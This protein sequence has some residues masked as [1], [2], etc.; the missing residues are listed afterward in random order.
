MRYA[1]PTWQPVGGRRGGDGSR[2]GGGAVSAVEVLAM[3]CA[4]G[5]LAVWLFYPLVIAAL[6]S[7]RRTGGGA[8]PE[9]RATVRP[10]T[11][12]IIIATCDDARTVRARVR[13]C[14]R[15]APDPGALEVVVGLDAGNARTTAHELTIP[16]DEAEPHSG[17]GSGTVRVVQGDAP[18][19]KAATL[20]A[21][22]RAARGD[23]LVFT[24][25]GQCFEPDAI[26]RLAEAFED[27]RVGAASGRLELGGGARRSL[28][29]RYWSYERWLR[30]CEATLHSC[31]GATGAIW[32]VRRSLWQPLPPRLIL[33]DVYAPMRVVLSGYRVAFV[34]AARALD[35]RVSDRTREYHRKVRTLTGV[36]QLCCWLPQLLLPSRN[37]LWVQFV[38]HK[39]LRLLTPYWLLGLLACGTLL[40]V[41]W[42]QSRPA[43][44]A[45]PVLALAA[46]SAAGKARALRVAREMLLWGFTLQLAVVA[47]GVNAARGRWDVWRTG[48]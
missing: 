28:A 3:F 37:P 40:G 24:D 30:R 26:A 15:A 8:S 31:V 13:D 17:L 39:L 4:G 23:L 33:D 46:V 11:V 27:E 32:A 10:R 14:L 1:A 16:D 9:T 34:D 20:N 41:H 22:V 35:Q 47:A 6:A 25:A 12:S 7:V 43:L 18:G 29:G 21:A 5:I 48:S 38:F 45:V 44:A 36:V 2:G 42:L 19:G